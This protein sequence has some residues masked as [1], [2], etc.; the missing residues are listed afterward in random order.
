LPIGRRR[1]WLQALSQARALT[2]ARGNG[3]I[4]AEALAPDERKTLGRA[5][6]QARRRELKVQSATLTLTPTTAT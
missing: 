4:T 6:D 3:A 5:I 1:S 2:G